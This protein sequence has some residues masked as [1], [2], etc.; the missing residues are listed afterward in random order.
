MAGTCQ[1]PQIELWSNS[2]LCGSLIA[3]IDSK[4][5]FESGKKTPFLDI[6]SFFVWQCGLQHDFFFNVISAPCHN[7]N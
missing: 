4:K 7:I 2:E 3:S 5:F 1:L 6:G